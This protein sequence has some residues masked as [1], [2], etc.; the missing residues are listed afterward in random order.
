M[1]KR[2]AGIVRWLDRCLKACKAGALESALMDVECARADMEELR[3]EVW[4]KLQ[5]RHSTRVRARFLWVPLKVVLWAFLVVL[6]GA[7]PLAL[8]QES[9]TLEKQEREAVSLEW[10]TPDEKALLGHLRKH[11]SNGNPFASI[12]IPAQPAAQRP[13]ARES[14]TRGFVAR[15]LP[16]QEPR[17]AR[18]DVIDIPYDRII[19]LVQAG[20]KAMQKDEPAIKVE[21]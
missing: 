11:L 1:E 2:I 6:T 4:K 20:E 7:T 13:S 16:K 3:N 21:R 8:F 14:V 10:V 5:R 9:L 12:Q 18:D 15:G 19:S 17:P